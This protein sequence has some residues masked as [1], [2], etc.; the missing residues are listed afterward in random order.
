M[1]IED[2]ERELIEEFEMFDDWMD[3]YNYIIDIGKNSP[4]LES[5]Y[6]TDENLVS[7]CTSQVWLHHE[8]KN[9][10][11]YFFSDSDA[12]IPKGIVAIIQRIYSDNEPSEIIH[13]KPVFIEKTGL[14]N[15]LTPNRANG[16]AS[17]IDRI[18]GIAARYIS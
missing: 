7:G 5:S 16:L 3:K 2:K 17:M 14:S 9:G 1:N 13:H 12:F 4:D 10:K 11:L 6:R 15:H 8:F 18:K